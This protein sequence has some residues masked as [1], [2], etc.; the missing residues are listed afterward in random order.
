MSYPA[1]SDGAGN[2]TLANEFGVTRKYT[3]AYYCGTF[4]CGDLVGLD[5]NAITVMG[6]RLVT[7]TTTNGVVRFG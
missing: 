7:G 6:G 4:A 5:T 2:I 3:P 1:T